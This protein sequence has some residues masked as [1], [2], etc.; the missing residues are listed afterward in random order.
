MKK[1]GTWY[2]PFFSACVI[3]PLARRVGISV[4]LQLPK[5]ARRVRLPY[6]APRQKKPAPFCFPGL[7]KGRESATSA[8]SFFLSKPEV[9]RGTSGLVLYYYSIKTRQSFRPELR[10]TSLSG[11]EIHKVFPAILPRKS[12]ST[13]YGIVVLKDDF[14]FC[15]SSGVEQPEPD[16]AAAEAGSRT[17]LHIERTRRCCISAESFLPIRYAL[18]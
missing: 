14:R 17:L 13:F 12:L 15:I 10:Q 6:P 16:S 4:L 18:W 9:S 2:L 5:L 7:R 3:L 11:L 8:V 1:A